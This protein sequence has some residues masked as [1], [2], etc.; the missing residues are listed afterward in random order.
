MRIGER[1]PTDITLGFAALAAVALAGLTHTEWGPLIHHAGHYDETAPA[2]TVF[3]WMTGW[4]LM[5]MALM[6]PAATPLIARTA[7]GRGFLATGF[8]GVWIAAGLAVLAI[9]L[10]SGQADE[11][12]IPAVLLI[13]AGTY[14]L[15]PSK[16]RA[17][18]QCRAHLRQAHGIGTD[19]TGDAMRRGIH[20][21][22][23]SLRCCGPLMAA[24]AVAPFG[25]LPGMLALGALAVA[26]EAA[27]GG[28]RLRIPLGLALIA[29]AVASLL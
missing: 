14:Q 3:A 26:E 2:L 5:A 16:R 13:L 27:P 21:G 7:Q 20:H 22:V 29:I 12:T 18:S 28:T 17:L 11:A 6:L 25:G 15:S 10:V 24:A 8:L 19:P 4:S 23:L 9:A 1:H